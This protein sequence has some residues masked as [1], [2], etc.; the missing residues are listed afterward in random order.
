[1]ESTI[2]NPLPNIKERIFSIDVIRGVALMGI[3]FIN[4]CTAGLT[5]AYDTGAIHFFDLNHADYYS[6]FM[7]N[8]LV[9]GKMRCLF[10]MLFG[11]GVI[12][13]TDNRIQQ[14]L[15]AAG[16]FYRRMLWLL[17]FGLIDVYIV[18]WN[19]DI[20]LEYAAC[21]LML[22][23]F[24]KLKPKYL[25]LIAVI[26]LAIVSW[27]SNMDFSEV[28]ASRETY[29]ATEQLVKENKKLTEEQQEER[30]AWINTTKS[31][32]PFSKETMKKVS[33]YIENDIRKRQAGYTDTFLRQA[34][35]N[36][37]EEYMAFLSP[38]WETLAT[39][40]LG[41]ALFKIGFFSNKYSRKKYLTIA[42]IC[43]AIGL[44]IAHEITYWP[45]SHAAKQYI[46]YV[47]THSFDLKALEQIPRILIPIGYA[48][49]LIIICMSGWLKKLTYALSCF[50]KMAFTNYMIQNIF[51]TVFFW[52]HGFA[53]FS[54]FTRIEIYGIMVITWIV[55][56]TFSVIWLRYYSMGPLE[57][58]WRTLTYKKIM[59][60]KITNE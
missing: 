30:D 3:L 26:M 40:L 49:L 13:F 55:Q 2:I 33:K 38:V 10:S 57:W 16:V 52:G 47:D 53:M 54:K 60:L 14:G 19:G 41:M 28:K 45:A 35:E 42:L 27:V 59:P 31:I 46:N 18:L 32:Y 12:L 36:F 25:V 15:P 7:V 51:I 56:I 5:S 29:L 22:Y 11:A 20:L 17:V 43:F 48:C 44:P 23:P 58:L 4:I 37:E 39:M 21:G 34:P 1:M 24:R 6:W 9:E 8:W 50:G